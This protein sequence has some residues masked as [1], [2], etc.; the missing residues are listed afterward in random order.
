[1]PGKDRWL[2]I[3]WSPFILIVVIFVWRK[4][5]LEINR[6][7]ISDTGIIFTNLLTRRKLELKKSEVIGF[8][9]TF[10]YGYKILLID[11]SGKVIAKIHEDYYKDFKGLVDNLGVGYMGRIPTIW[12][13]FFGD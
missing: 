6:I 8:K 3:Y 5:I 9:D 12:D 11:Q 7:E 10:Q 4:I 13:R 2:L 1:M